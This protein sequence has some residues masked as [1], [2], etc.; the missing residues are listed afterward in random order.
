MK[1]IGAAILCTFASVA[2]AEGLPQTYH[3]RW[4]P[5]GSSCGDAETAVNVM[6]KWLMVGDAACEIERSAGM[7]DGVLIYATCSLEG[8]EEVQT[9]WLLSLDGHN[10]LSL[11]KYDLG[12]KTDTT[13]Y[14]RCDRAT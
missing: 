8:V 2:L 3:G 1:I 4:S 5:V 9:K 6:P 14:G 13:T 7:S 10:A 11:S 12:A